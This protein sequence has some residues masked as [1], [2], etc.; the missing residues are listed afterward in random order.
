MG[1]LMGRNGFRAKFCMPI[2][3]E[4]IDPPYAPARFSG[5]TQD[6]SESGIRALLPHPL[7]V[8]TSLT[9]EAQIPLQQ[10][11]YPFLAVGKVLRIH[12]VSSQASPKLFPTAIRFVSFRKGGL[13]VLEPLM[14]ILR[15]REL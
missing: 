13:E 14:D 2:H 12:A 9:I 6:I 7:S 8:G 11:K 10:K 3:C 15:R 1:C 4:V 5:T